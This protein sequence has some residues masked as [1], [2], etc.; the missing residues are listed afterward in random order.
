MTDYDAIQ[1][2]LRGRSGFIT[3]PPEANLVPMPSADE[4]LYRSLSGLDG[5]KPVPMPEPPPSL[6]RNAGRM[7][8]ISE[9][10]AARRL[11]NMLRQD[12]APPEPATPKYPPIRGTGY[13]IPAIPPRE[14]FAPSNSERRGLPST[15][16]SENETLLNKLLKAAAT[17]RNRITRNEPMTVAERQ[18]E[19]GKGPAAQESGARE[20][21]LQLAADQGARNQTSRS[22]SFN[23]G[24]PT[25]A[26]VDETAMLGA[27]K[28]DPAGPYEGQLITLNPVDAY[29]ANEAAQESLQA[30]I[31]RFPQSP[32]HNDPGDAFRHA[33]W[34]YKL[35][36]LLGPER[37][38]DFTDSHEISNPN[39]RGERLMDLYNNEVG[40]RLAA[41]SAG[42]QRSDEEVVLE[43][44]KRGE[45][46][47]KPFSVLPGT[48]LASPAKSAPSRY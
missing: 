26:P 46:Q 44:L 7:A 47:Q 14:T 22:K 31:N 4:L 6:L 13:R 36:R 37:A 28:F 1:R 23:V 18:N 38:K 17:D 16:E 45:L 32:R 8:E 10:E 5:S 40:R 30:A 33:L 34:S 39:S 21:T 12:Y 41:G 11:S 29:R 43:A 20:A 15:R 48:E 24:S 42:Q 27:L 9:A 25:N 19:L 3:P 35:T 2:W